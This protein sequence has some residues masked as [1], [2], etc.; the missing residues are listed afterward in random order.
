MDTREYKNI[1]EHEA[2]H[3]YYVGYHNILLSLLEKY[4]PKKGDLK[5]LDAGCGTGLFTKKLGKF[6]DVI[7]VDASAEALKFARKRGIKV[8]KA[9]ITKLPF[10]DNTFDLIVSNDVICHKS[11]KSDQKAINELS[12]VLA[13]GGLLLLK[14]P[15]FN[16][17]KGAHDA[18]VF[19]KKRYGKNDVQK[20]LWAAGH[21]PVKSSFAGSFLVPVVILKNAVDRTTGKHS[22][23]SVASVWQPLNKFLISLFNIERVIISFL[24]IPVGIT[25]ITVS[26]K[27]EK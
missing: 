10:K 13:P 9:L 4:L 6:G 11:I 25:I 22:D 21:L 16:W 12:R 8:K 3:F 20:M 1:Y 15:A 26:R 18:R 14:L 24:N 7:G 2:T 17:L 5:I 19:T 23:S 27:Q